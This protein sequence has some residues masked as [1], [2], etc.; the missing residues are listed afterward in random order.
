MLLAT[1]S[2]RGQTTGHQPAGEHD[3]KGGL[4]GRLGAGNEPGRRGTPK[5][6]GQPPSC[7]ARLAERGRLTRFYPMLPWCQPIVPKDY[8]NR[9]NTGRGRGPRGHRYPGYYVA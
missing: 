9:V 6:H 2:H 5:L 8:I 7:F 4:A 1:T 3:S